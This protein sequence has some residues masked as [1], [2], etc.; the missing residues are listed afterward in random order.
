[1]QLQPDEKIAALLTL[2]DFPEQE[3]QQFIVMGTRK[4]TVKKTDLSSFSNPRPSG[5][6][7]M[8]IDDGDTV[9]AVEIS[10]GKEQVFIGTSDGM[11]IRFEETDVRPTGRGTFGVRGITLMAAN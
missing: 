1:M 3:D 11:A 8:G 5:I 7:A 4:G 6:I 2:K 10:D 9:I